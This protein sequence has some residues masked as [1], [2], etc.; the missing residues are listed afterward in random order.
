M[1]I[2]VEKFGEAMLL[3]MGYQKGKP[4]GRSNSVI[5]PTSFAKLPKGAGLGSV[6][7]NRALNE[8]KKKNDEKGK[9][10]KGITLES[11]LQ[12]NNGN[13]LIKKNVLVSILNG[14]YEGLIGRIL[15]ENRGKLKDKVLVR[16]NLKNKLEVEEKI[17]YLQFLSIK[18]FPRLHEACR[19][20]RSEIMTPEDIQEAK[21]S[22][23]KKEKAPVNTRTTKKKEKKKKK[24]KKRKNK[25]VVPNIKVRIISKTYQKG[26]YYLK[27][28][29]VVDVPDNYSCS[30]QIDKLILEEVRERMIETIIPKKKNSPVI[31]VLG[32]HKGKKGIL[33][34]RNSKKS[35]CTIQIN[36][37]LEFVTC[38][39]DE[40]CERSSINY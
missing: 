30:I 7:L 11:W 10:K 31:F 25:W 8:D 27:K 28:G 23:D 20:A 14:P 21:Q 2:P 1:S 38:S 3:G 16:L 5:Q 18:G 24:K 35:Q 39:F 26:K 22:L 36:Q 33:L 6:L 32:K 4:F 12:K 19:F 13:E 37:S 34:N 40:I 29:I 17:E 9:K 15:D